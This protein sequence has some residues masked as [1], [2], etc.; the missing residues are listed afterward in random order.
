MGLT[1]RPER[2]YA[3]Y[4]FDCDGTLADSMPVHHQA[5]VYALKKNGATFEFTYEQMCHWGG[6]SLYETVRKLNTIHNGCLDPEKVVQDQVERIAEHLP[7]VK[8]REHV[9]AV[10]LE[11]ADKSPLAVA[12]GGCRQNVHT[13]LEAIGL[14][15]IFQVIITHEDVVQSKPSPEIFLLA[16]SRLGVEAEDCLVYEDSVTG[17]EAAKAAGM[18]YILV[19]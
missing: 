18:D 2:E 5:W 15:Q 14:K 9:A 19:D 17:I 3:A 10:A 11:L 4:I 1:I 8:P 6:M 7:Y 12:S 13:T 16:A